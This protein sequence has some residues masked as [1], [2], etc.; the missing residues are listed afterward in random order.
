M[1]VLPFKTKPKINYKPLVVMFA[2]A[3]V[4]SLT[5]PAH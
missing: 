1:E 4:M 5:E 2:N 3:I